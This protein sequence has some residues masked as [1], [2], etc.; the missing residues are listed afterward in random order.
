MASQTIR[1]EKTDTFGGE[2]NYSWVT[3]GEIDIPTDLSD[4]ALVR[5]IKRE[6]GW[7][8]LRCRRQNLGEIIE[9]RPYGLCQVCFINV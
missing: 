9:L 1:Y 7:T 5:R 3:K 4:L 2:A 8:G 6:I